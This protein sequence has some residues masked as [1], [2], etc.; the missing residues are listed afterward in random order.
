MVGAARGE[1]KSPATDRW[2]RASRAR[3]SACYKTRVRFARR[4]ISF[5]YACQA[6][7]AICICNAE[8]LFPK[9]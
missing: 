2:P 9:T 1:T 4:T 7:G 8:R 6:R 3:P 5:E